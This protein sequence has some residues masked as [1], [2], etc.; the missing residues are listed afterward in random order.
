[1]DYYNEKLAEI[2]AAEQE[3]NR[4][5]VVERKAVSNLFLT[6]TLLSNTLLSKDFRAIQRLFFVTATRTVSWFMRTRTEIKFLSLKALKTQLLLK[7]I[8][9]PT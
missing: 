5:D 6:T 2:N 8:L 4:S 7:N 1:M 3:R 9:Y